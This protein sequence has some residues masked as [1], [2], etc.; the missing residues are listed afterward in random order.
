M[1]PLL[2]LFIFFTIAVLPIMPV[3]N[4]VVNYDYIVENLCENKDK[5]ELSCKG[6]CFLKKELSKT[7]KQTTQTT[8]KTIALDI[9]IPND[10]F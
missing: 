6:K 9:F 4:H 3:Y 7:E 2:F 5:P 1:R 10:I 8:A